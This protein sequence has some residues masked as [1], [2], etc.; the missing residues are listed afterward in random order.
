MINFYGYFMLFL[1]ITFCVKKTLSLFIQSLCLLN[2]IPG[3]R[4]LPWQIR[5]FWWDFVFQKCSRTFEI[6]SWM[7]KHAT[8][9]FKGAATYFLVIQKI[10]QMILQMIFQPCS[11]RFKHTVARLKYAIEPVRQVAACLIANM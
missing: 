3:Y 5:T 8:T 6:C 11:R 4:K 1:M 10:F 9:C 7:F 2:F